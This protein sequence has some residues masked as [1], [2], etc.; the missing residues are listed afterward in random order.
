[1]T[2]V[3]PQQGVEANGVLAGQ[4]AVDRRIAEE[5]QLAVLESRQATRGLSQIPGRHALAQAG[6]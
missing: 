5:Q 2:A 3:V 4:M 1:M 6:A